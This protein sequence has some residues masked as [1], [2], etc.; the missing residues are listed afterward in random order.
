MV[1]NGFG[2]QM[3][4]NRSKA[5]AAIIV[6]FAILYDYYLLSGFF[7]W[8]LDSFYRKAYIYSSSM[9]YVCS[10][11]YLGNN[12]NKSKLEN[13]FRNIG[14]C[15]FALFCIGVI[16][17][18]LYIISNPLFY[19]LLFCSLTIILVFFFIFKADKEGN[20]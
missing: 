6:A 2:Y 9:I 20:I 17:T 14:C 4:V 13:S 1:A 11:I 15:F 10:L 12:N 8:F 18:N 5:T 16:L 7:G 3:L 19:C